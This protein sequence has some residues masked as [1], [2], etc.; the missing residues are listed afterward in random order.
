MVCASLSPGA[1]YAVGQRISRGR[2]H[3]GE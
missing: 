1:A 2:C 3:C